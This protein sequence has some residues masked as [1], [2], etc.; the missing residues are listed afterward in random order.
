M[1]KKSGDLLML[2]RSSEAVLEDLAKTPSMPP[3]STPHMSRVH[4]KVTAIANA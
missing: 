3:C 1:K 2:R 4:A